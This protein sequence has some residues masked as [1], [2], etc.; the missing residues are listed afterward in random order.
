MFMVEIAGIKV[1]YTGDY[2]CEEDR[3]L[4]PA[5]VPDMP[6]DI[7][8]VESTY[9]V[10]IHEPRLD[11]ERLFTTTVQNIVKSGGRCLLPVFALGRAQELLLIL[12]EY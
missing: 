6:V 7:L 9:G 10:Q 4:L 11:R 12:D 3:H 5:R 2:S 1:L 8:I